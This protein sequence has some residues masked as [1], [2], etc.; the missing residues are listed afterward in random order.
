MPHVC[1]RSILIYDY[2]IN[3]F[4]E[5]SNEY[6]DLYCPQSFKCIVYND[7]NMIDGNKQERKVYSCESR[8]NESISKYLD[9]NAFIE[10]LFPY[11]LIPTDSSP[12]IFIHKLI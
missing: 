3:D 5:L 10:D 7:N 2:Y 4:K 9:D 8:I 11:G 6:L 1:I 12:L